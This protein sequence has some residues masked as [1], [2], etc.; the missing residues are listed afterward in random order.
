MLSSAQETGIWAW[1]C[2]QK[3]AVLIIPSV[4][5]LLGDNPM[6]SEFACHIG[7]RGKYFCRICHVKGR[8]VQD[9]AVNADAQPPAGGQRRRGSGGSAGSAAASG[10][11]GGGQA[12]DLESMDDMVKRA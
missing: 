4:I 10:S 1:D 11:D 7:L 3:A 6:Q 5:A 8:D 12:K 2:A 9:E